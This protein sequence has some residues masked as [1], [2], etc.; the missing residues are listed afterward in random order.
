MIGSD[1]LTNTAGFSLSRALF[2]K[3]MWGPLNNIR[4]ARLN[5]HDTH[6]DS[7]VIID[8]LLRTRIIY[9]VFQKSYAKIEITI[10]TANL[11]IIIYPFS[12]FNYRL[13][14]VNFANFNRIHRSF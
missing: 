5:L 8:V 3:K 12:S 2:R 14:G 6:S 9:T 10:T 1:I 13:F 7:V 4:I 11:I